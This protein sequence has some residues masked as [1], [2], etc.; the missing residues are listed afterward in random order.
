M[1]SMKRLRPELF[2]NN[3]YMDESYSQGFDGK[4]KTVSP[5]V[6]MSKTWNG[7]RLPTRP[8]G[9]DEPTWM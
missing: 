6:K 5:V 7:F 3:D 2:E 4:V 9:Y 1:K 8:N